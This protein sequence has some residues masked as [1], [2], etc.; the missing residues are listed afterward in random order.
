ML[1]EAPIQARQA[2]RPRA[3][4]AF[5]TRRIE[6]SAVAAITI[7]AGVLRLAT[8]HIQ[9]FDEDEAVTVA[10]LHHSFGG[11][12]ATIPHTEQTPP[13]YYILAWLWARA[14]GFG[15]VGLRSLSAVAG[16]LLVPVMYTTGKE[17]GSR[18]AGFIAAALTTFNPLLFWYSQEARSYALMALLS[19]LAFA[20]FA[21]AYVDRRDRTRKVRGLWGWAICS[22]LAMATHYFALFLAIPEG[23]LLLAGASAAKRRPVALALALPTV[24]ALALAPLALYQRSP[25]KYSF[26]GLSSL[27]SRTV[28]LPRQLLLGYALPHGVAWTA[29]VVVLMLIAAWG[30]GRAD[31]RRVLAVCGWV[32]ACGLGIPLL[33]ALAGIDL[34]VT[35]NFVAVLV[36]CLVAAA[37]G[38]STGRL[39]AFAAVGVC[40]IWLASLVVVDTDV[41]LQRPAWRQAAMALGPA[42]VNRAIVVVPGYRGAAPLGIYLP[43]SEP[44]SRDDPPVTE[45]AEIGLPATQLTP[46][47]LSLRAPLPGF[48]AVARHDTSGYSEVI[49]RAARATRLSPRV[50]IPI[51][52]VTSPGQLGP[53]LIGTVIVQRA[54]AQERSSF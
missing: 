27:G 39:G 53:T 34:V 31:G 30:L 51:R 45:L 2:L 37:V 49:Y 21:R 22:S 4:P 52:T 6:L 32:A 20:F 40:V 13:L 41:Q 26:I 48:V 5:G 54:R 7:V 3:V 50:P 25:E 38:F 16:T 17:L 28:S 15:E 44:L 46:I 9:S 14:F 43:R 42:S 23:V 47:Q 33:L 1:A 35:R 24:A 19:G 12:L 10:L 36:P 11:M 8:L 18:R 29:T